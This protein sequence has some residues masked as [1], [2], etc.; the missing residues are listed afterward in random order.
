MAIS[1]PVDQYI[2]GQSDPENLIGV[3]TEIRIDLDLTP[4]PNIGA[5]GVTG[6]ITDPAGKPIPG[7]TV[8]L[9][10]A[11]HNPVAHT[12]SGPDGRYSFVNLLPSPQYILV[13]Q[14]N[15]YLLTPQTPFALGPNQQVVI[16]L[17]PEPDPNV[18][19][20]IISGVVHRLDN[21][22]PVVSATAALFQ[23]PA[24]GLDILVQTTTT[25]KTGQFVFMDVATGNYRIITSMQGFFSNTTLLSVTTPGSIVNVNVELIVNPVSA[26]GTVNGVI[27][28]NAGSPI[29]GATVVLFRENADGSLIPLYFT[30]TNNAGLYLFTEVAEG[31][32]RIKANSFLRTA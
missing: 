30:R 4:N 2:L 21:N 13:C 11:N 7:A 22:K 12:I 31:K 26:K 29:P 16:N 3:G 14:A 24:A 5:G 28:N 8:K 18:A 20:S 23:I 25:N 6:V 9:L 17:S 32:Y 27:R 19:F 10:D 15:G 1:I